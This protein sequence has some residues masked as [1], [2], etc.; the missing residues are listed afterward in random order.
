MI[1]LNFNETD[2]KKIISNW[3]PCGLLED[4]NRNMRRYVAIS[5]NKTGKYIKETTLPLWDDNINMLV[6]PIIRRICSDIDKDDKHIHGGGGF[7]ID[8]RKKY[9]LENFNPEWLVE[10]ISET[11]YPCIVYVRSLT[12]GLDIDLEAEICATLAEDIGIRLMLKYN[13]IG[14]E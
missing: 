9:I 1:D 8:E 7:T 11:Y 6:F 13:R 2:E 4:L 10:K 3:E 5:M 12:R 14:R